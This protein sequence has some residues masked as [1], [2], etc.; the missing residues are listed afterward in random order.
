MQKSGCSHSAAA[1]PPLLL[2]AYGLLLAVLLAACARG[3]AP[4]DEFR[5]GLLGPLTGAAQPYT[6][7]LW[8]ERLVAGINAQGG[9]D[10]GG[11]KLKVRLLVADTGSQMERALSAAVRLIQHERVSALVGPYYSRQAILVANATEAAQVPMVTPTASSPQVTQGR[12]YAFRICLV[13][14]L[15]GQF[16]ARFAFQDLGLRRVAV[17]YDESDEY[18]RGLARYFADAFERLGGQVERLSHPSGRTDFSAQIR[19]IRA[20]G[21]QALFLPNYA[22]DVVRQMIQARA[23]GFGG[24]FLG[25]DSWEG[26][27]AVTALPQAQGS[28]FSANFS[29][30]YMSADIRREAERL[31]AEAGVPLDSDEALALDALG[32]ILAAARAV[33]SV[34]PV[35]L[36]AGLASLRGYEGFT[37]Q[38]SFEAGGDAVRGAHILAIKGGQARCRR[39]LEPE[40]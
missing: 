20:A 9:L 18:T 14:T 34:D 17:L 33:G 32:V 6:G 24:L 2:L 25:G 15:Q 23:G 26:D 27:K 21:S 40:L 8:A 10:V 13:D 3:D 22:Q 19:R 7:H 36:R 11:R 12:S 38:L 35:S 28:F 4:E 39:I 29:S 37:G 30:E 16:L 31:R 1:R 5:I